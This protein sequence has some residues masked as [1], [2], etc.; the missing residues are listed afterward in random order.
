M[1]GRAFSRVIAQAACDSP[2]KL[3]RMEAVNCIDMS[4]FCD[5]IECKGTRTAS[6]AGSPAVAGG[7]LAAVGCLDRCFP[8]TN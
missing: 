4:I 5:I 8:D 7:E 1:G 3:F 2:G 6:P